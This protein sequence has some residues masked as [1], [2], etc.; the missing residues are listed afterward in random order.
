MLDSYA[1]TSSPVPFSF[2][3]SLELYLGF[4]LLTFVCEYLRALS[5]SA[6]TSSTVPFSRFNFLNGTVC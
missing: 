1:V 2:F 6:V 3:G 5:F 4:D